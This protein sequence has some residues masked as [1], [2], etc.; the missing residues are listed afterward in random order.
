MATMMVLVAVM[1]QRTPFQYHTGICTPIL[2]I[3]PSINVKRK[4]NEEFKSVAAVVQRTAFDVDLMVWL[5]NEDGGWGER[6]RVK[7]KN[8]EANVRVGG[9]IG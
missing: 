7:R 1:L 8:G 4:I 2:R 6:G 9:G 3:K 5:T